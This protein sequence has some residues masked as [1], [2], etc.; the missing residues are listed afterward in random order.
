ML[1]PP[2]APTTVP[3]A[4]ILGIGAG[5]VLLAILVA[6]LL[7]W[8]DVIPHA[9]AEIRH[10]AQD[11]AEEIQAARTAVFARDPDADTITFGK[12]NVDWIGEAPA[13]CGLVDIDE[14]QDSLDGEER[15]VFIDGGLTLESL[16]GSAAVQQKWKGV[17]DDV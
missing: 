5:L 12:V 4:L 2:A 17:C 13:V 6:G 8:D 11:E 3:R 7:F 14:P 15:F 16:D 9:R 1:K 10:E